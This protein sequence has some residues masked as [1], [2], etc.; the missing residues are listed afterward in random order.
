MYHYFVLMATDSLT[1]NILAW[2][3]LNPEHFWCS[4]SIVTDL[5]TGVVLLR[6]DATQAS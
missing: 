5:R 1:E 3:S 6:I 4:G 2:H